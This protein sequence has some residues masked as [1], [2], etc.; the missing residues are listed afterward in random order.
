MLDSKLEK[1]QR[2]E[3]EGD[4]LEAIKLYQ[5]VY[6][7]QS[8][9]NP[10]A[11]KIAQLAYQAGDHKTAIKYYEILAPNGNPTVLYNLACSCALAGKERKA[12]KYL[13]LAVENGFNQVSVMRNDPDLENIRGHKQFNE[14][15]SSAKSIENILEAQAFDFWVG[16]WE[17]Y[18]PSN[19]KVGESRIEKILKNAVIL[20]NWTGVS[21]YSGKSFNH[22]HIDS[23]KWIQ[24]WVDQAS[25]R[26]HFE[27]N[28]DPETGAIVFFE[29]NTQGA[30]LKKLSFYNISSDS[31]RQHSEVRGAEDQPWNTEYNFVYIRK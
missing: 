29:V 6:Q 11:F 30:S 8:N 13:K 28:F 9:N 10:L 15:V 12:I 1:A 25:G 4:T 21:G 31:V 7:K 23:G 22:Y 16:E 26:I 2:L 24:Y 17:V 14:I 18:N 5:E 27:G 20:E 19:Q 3:T